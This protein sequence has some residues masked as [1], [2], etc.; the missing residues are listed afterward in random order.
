MDARISEPPNAL[1]GI[2]HDPTTE[3]VAACR[4]Q[5]SQ[6]ARVARFHSHRGLDLHAPRLPPASNDEIHF[7]PIPI[8][9]VPEPQVGVGPGRLGDELL[10]D[11]RFEKTAHCGPVAKPV[12]ARPFRKSRGESGIREMNLGR[13]HESFAG[14][15]VPGQQAPDEEH[16][17][18]H[19]QVVRHRF[20]T[21]GESVRQTAHIEERG[22]S[23]RQQF[24]QPSQVGGAAHPAH[25]PDVPLQDLVQVVA[26]PLPDPSRR[27]GEGFRIATLQEALDERTGIR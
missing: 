8:P 26:M 21:D 22:G 3:V 6:A 7:V 18:Q 11:E 5:A 4:G 9:V 27:A 12:G 16:A 14:G 1:P 25:F 23:S 2:D 15:P 24:Q 13:P 10:N 20:P 19:F 17:L